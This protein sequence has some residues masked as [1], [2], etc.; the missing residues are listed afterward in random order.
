MTEI[1]P[2]IAEPSR[3]ALFLDFDGTLVG[4]AD[5]PDAVEVPA[6]LVAS[7]DTLATRFEGALALV[8][9]RRIDSLD[10]LLAPL[11]LPAAGVHGLQM[12]YA[13]TTQ[14]NAAAAG[15]LEP[16]RE[17]LKA[18]IGPADPIRI[19]DKGGAIV[20]HYRAA[21]QAGERARAIAGA[22]AA[23]SG[24][25]VA[26]GGHAIVEIRP[27]AITKAG[28]IRAFLERPPFAG[29]NPIFIGDDVTDEDGMAA[30][31]AIGGYGIKVGPGETVARYRLDDIAAVHHWLAALAASD[32][33]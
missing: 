29:R 5:D 23:L 20:L 10:R 32:G 30:A 1:S 11:R 8:S 28:A 12:R 2:P 22:A 25:L 7:L 21:P 26:V 14:S 27:R 4:F 6:G 31:E 33:K 17:F 18:E 24:E 16:A 3:H 15:H 9:G 13:D 19:E